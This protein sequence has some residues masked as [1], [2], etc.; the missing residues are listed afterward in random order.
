VFSFPRLILFSLAVFGDVVRVLPKN[1]RQAWNF[2]F[3]NYDPLENL[4]SRKSFTNSV[5]RLLET[6]RI[7]KTVEKGRVKIK[8]TSKGLKFL[9]LSLD[10]AKFQRRT[11]D[12]KWRMVIFDVEEKYRNQRNYLRR[13]L[14]NLGFGML[15][16]S[17]WISPFPIENELNEL[18]VTWRL[19]GSLIASRSEI[20]VGDQRHLAEEVWS[21]SRVK[22]RYLRLKN[23]W[24]SLGKIS[25]N[26]LNAFKFQELF[27]QAMWLDPFLPTELLPDDWP[28]ESTKKIYLK[29]T[30]KELGR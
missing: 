2:W 13:Q 7:E 24:G 20:L 26:K 1:K 10:L 9:S 12:K 27:F 28:F 11:W 15:Q 25:K 18:F 29:E 4:F 19:K 14:E 6:E 30:L 3:G 8:V 22:F 16:E 23:W 17:V 21:L 5:S